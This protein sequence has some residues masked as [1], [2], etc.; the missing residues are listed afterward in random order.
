MASH[1]PILGIDLS[2]RQLATVVLRGK[3]ER[4]QR[5]QS[6]ALDGPA[7]VHVDQDGLVSTG[8]HARARALSD[9][10]GA[11]AHLA[12]SIG[13]DRATS[14]DD[15]S[16]FP[17]P[18]AEPTV[19]GPCFSLRG[20]EWSVESLVACLLSRVRAV[21]SDL[22]G[23]PIAIVVI[24][25]PS[26]YS[27]AARAR[28]LVAARAAGFER[29][30]AIPSA[31]A[32]A[33]ALHDAGERGTI[34]LVEHESAVVGTAVVELT[35]D[36]IELERFGGRPL[37][38]GTGLVGRLSRFL[39]EPFGGDVSLDAS[40]RPRAVARLHDECEAA[41]ARLR[42]LPKA[43]AVVEVPFLALPASGPR[44]LRGQVD[45]DRLRDLARPVIAVFEDELAAS[46][47][48]T[49]PDRVSRW[50]LTGGA[51]SITFL[52]QALRARSARDV[53]LDPQRTPWA[54]IGAVIHGAR[55]EG[56]LPDVF[57]L[58]VAPH[59]IG[60]RN[61]DGGVLRFVDRFAPLPATVSG[62]YPVAALE[63][64]PVELVE[65]DVDRAELGVPL[66]SFR[67]A[68]ATGQRNDFRR[69]ELVVEADAE[70]QAAVGVRAPGALEAIPLERLPDPARSAASVTAELDRLIEAQRL[71]DGLL[72]ARAL[73]RGHMLAA[74][75]WLG[76]GRSRGDGEPERAL[77]V[78]IDRASAAIQGSD[79][80]HIQMAVRGLAERMRASA[81]GEVAAS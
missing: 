29:V 14:D 69:I 11:A 66:A 65:G 59:A 61:P 1:E 36:A 60:V 45:L 72:R 49:S 23:Q 77:L 80:E 16:L 76:E 8:L 47:R 44:H 40:L 42:A 6:A 41:L 34:G 56:D 71:H 32:I 38:F 15:R 10:D 54:A 13:L 30:H 81:V 53:R 55:R 75:R 5:V 67:L 51:P 70:G 48:I 4:L 79:L 68:S 27:A 62:P 20:V 7:A 31:A 64:E 52:G 19:S 33:V 35:D 22:V 24:A 37:A 74:S 50:I 26:W 25:Y 28:L 46:A 9:P 39:A 63:R 58:R 2:D 43:P 78:A 73:L 18:V 3:G 57:L 17:F 12:R 21:A